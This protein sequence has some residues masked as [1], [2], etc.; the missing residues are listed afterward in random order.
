MCRQALAHDGNLHIYILELTTWLTSTRKSNYDFI[1]PLRAFTS[2]FASIQGTAVDV[3]V[4][5]GS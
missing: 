4:R 1:S 5:A 2:L 3:Q